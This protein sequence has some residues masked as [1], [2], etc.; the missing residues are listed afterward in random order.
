M[1]YISSFHDASTFSGGRGVSP[2]HCGLCLIV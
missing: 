1:F 2:L